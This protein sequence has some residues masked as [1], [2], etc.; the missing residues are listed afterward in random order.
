MS[1]KPSLHVKLANGLHLTVCQIYSSI[2]GRR[3]GVVGMNVND[4]DVDVD[5][6]SQP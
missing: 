2:S 6:E 4:G 1:E 3:L 5:D